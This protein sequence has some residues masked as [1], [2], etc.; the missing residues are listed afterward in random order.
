[1]RFTSVL[2]R[3]AQLYGEFIG[4]FLVALVLLLAGLNLVVT[5]L[6]RPGQDNVGRALLLFLAT[7]V[8]TAWGQA[9]MVEDIRDHREGRGDVAML[10]LFGRT[11]R[12]AL[13]VAWA[14][15]LASLIIGMLFGVIFFF[16]TIFVVDEWTL[17]TALLVAAA[18]TLFL[19]ARWSL[20]VPV[21]VIEQRTTSAAFARSTELVLPYRWTVLF[22]VLAG[23]LVGFAFELVLASAVDR[24][25][26]GWVET[27]L[28]RL[29]D[30]LIYTSIV[31][32]V[33]TTLYYELVGAPTSTRT[34]P[35][36]RGDDLQPW[37]P[38][39]TRLSR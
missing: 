2:G 6:D 29:I 22:V 17:L 1:M 31:T 11:W 26:G 12:I 14:T 30:G 28:V 9:T 5:L 39:V 27:W 37:A 13:R 34:T 3:V 38:E 16:A 4:R 7:L 8:A 10:E 32:A 18:P 24:A 15:F 21:I 33:S 35:A 20:L 36:G 23:F 19:A 25:A